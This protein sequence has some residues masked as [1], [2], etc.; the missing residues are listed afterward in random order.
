MDNADL[1][2]EILRLATPRVPD[3]EALA[4][5]VSSAR[6]QAFEKGR[7]LARAGDPAEGL[8][9]I[10]QG[11]VRYYFLADGVEHTGQF[12]DDG[13]FFADVSALTT[14][15][16]GLQNIDALAPTRAVLIPRA[17]LFAA[18]DADHALERFG[19]R[20]IEEA[21][22]GVQRRNA[23]LLQLSAETRYARL[24]EM[25]PEIVRRIPQYVVASYLG[26]TPEALSRIRRRRIA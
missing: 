3:P 17:A 19:R 9:F 20:L 15:Q 5:L 12:F 6:E 16:P 24:I 13:M 23:A 7:H 2:A 18:Y 25:R 4:V 10:R 1:M 14:G 11:L 26:I 22:A 21:M 8:W